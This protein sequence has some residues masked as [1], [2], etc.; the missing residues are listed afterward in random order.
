[1][2]VFEV[3]FGGQ[4]KTCL[5]GSE[6]KAVD[7]H[8]FVKDLKLSRAI[9][10]KQ[11]LVVDNLFIYFNDLKVYKVVVQ[12]NPSM[13]KKASRLGFRDSYH[14]IFMDDV[15][16]K[17]TDLNVSKGSFIAIYNPNTCDCSI[18]HGEESE[19]QQ[20]QRICS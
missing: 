16:I 17:I 20:L 10:Q 4:L 19:E 8:E 13:M 11:C 3:S 12:V 15:P 5:I 14:T 1:M 2:L 18:Y 6:M 9:T 7:L